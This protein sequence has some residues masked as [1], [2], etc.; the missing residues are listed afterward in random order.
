MTSC[1]RYAEVVSA[2]G[3]KDDDE[4]VTWFGKNKP[5]H[6]RELIAQEL[7]QLLL[8][9]SLKAHR[10]DRK[11]KWSSPEFCPTIEEIWTEFEQNTDLPLLYYNLTPEG[12]SRWEATSKADWSKFVEIRESSRDWPPLR[13]Y[14]RATS[15]NHLSIGQDLREERFNGKAFQYETARWSLIRNWQATYWKT[16]PLVCRLTGI[17]VRVAPEPLFHPWSRR[18]F[19]WY[20]D[21]WAEPS[22]YPRIAVPEPGQPI[23]KVPPPSWGFDIHGWQWNEDLFEE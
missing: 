4:F 14:Y 10:T 22:T 3:A 23:P 16:L 18:R 2:L 13:S 15:A 5:T 19:D 8:E 17:L 12:G 20:T 7:H 9:G 21:P 11:A 6:D 1:I